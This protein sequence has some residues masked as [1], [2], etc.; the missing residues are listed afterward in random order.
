MPGSQERDKDEKNTD[1]AYVSQVGKALCVLLC[2]LK[3]KRIVISGARI[4]VCVGVCISK[5]TIDTHNHKKMKQKPTHKEIQF[6]R[7]F[8]DDE[9]T[10]LL[11]YTCIYCF[12]TFSKI[13]F[14]K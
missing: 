4:S 7:H 5:S 14:S 12:D 10:H 9:I 1:N 11:I 8:L 3:G 13:F 6:K 2:L